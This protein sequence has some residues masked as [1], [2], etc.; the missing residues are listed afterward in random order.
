MTFQKMPAVEIVQLTLEGAPSAVLA[1]RQ[2]VVRAA[3]DNE[4]RSSSTF[5]LVCVLSF[6][7]KKITNKMLVY[8]DLY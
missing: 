3:E 8:I 4:D 1:A 6:S 2:P 7:P 5:W